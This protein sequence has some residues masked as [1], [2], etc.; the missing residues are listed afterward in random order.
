VQLRSPRRERRCWAPRRE[1]RRATAP[2]R[3]P[4]AGFWTMERSTRSTVVFMIRLQERAFGRGHHRLWCSN[5]LRRSRETCGR[6]SERPCLAGSISSAADCSVA[7]SK[8]ARLLPTSARTGSASSARAQWS[9]AATDAVIDGSGPRLAR[10]C[11]KGRI[12]AV[13][14]NE[15]IVPGGRNGG[16]RG[17]L[18]ERNYV[19]SLP[20]GTPAKR[21]PLYMCSR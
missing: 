17:S 13:P 14:P 19:C 7:S 11:A 5:G 8:S 18:A 10:R 6:P 2:L 9:A 1:Y 20:S 3:S 16:F 4:C 21:N 15:A 12:A